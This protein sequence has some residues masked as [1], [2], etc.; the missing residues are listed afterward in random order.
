MGNAV[1]G[2]TE[3]LEYALTSTSGNPWTNPEDATLISVPI[4]KLMADGFQN[5][6]EEAQLAQ[7]IN[8]LEASAAKKGVAIW[9]VAYADDD[10]FLDTLIAA[11]KAFTPVWFFPKPVGEVKRVL[12]GPTGGLVYVNQNPLP[13]FGSLVRALIGFSATGPTPG[14]TYKLVPGSGS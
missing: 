7:T 2:V 5:F 10:T 9:P 14:S 11:E 13:Q 3:S 12:G 1:R 6:S 4:L 8:Q